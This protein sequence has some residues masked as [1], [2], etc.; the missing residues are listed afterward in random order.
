[1]SRRADFQALTLALLLAA[2]VGCGGDGPREPL[3]VLLVTFDTTRADHIGAYGHAGARTPVLDDLAAQGVLFESAYAP[4]PITLPSHSSL[5]TGKVPFAH[6]VRDNGLFVLGDEQLTLAEIL[7]DRGYRTAAAIASFPLTA[8]FGINQ[9]FELF[10]DHVTADMEDLYGQRSAPKSGIFFDERSAGRVNDAVLPWLE[11]HADEPFFL[12]AHYFDPHHPHTPPPPYDQLFA[13]ELY[14]GE[15]AYAD[16]SL[17]VVLQKL[18]DLGVLDHTLVVFTSDHGEGR[19]EHGEST[20]SL[21][22]YNST[23]H[24]P[25]IISN[26]RLSSELG[27]RRVQQAVSTVDVLPTILELIGLELPAELDGQLQGQSLGRYFQDQPDDGDGRSRRQLYAETLSPRLS[28]QW[29][30]LRTLYYG[31]YKF[32]HGPRPELYDLAADP[33]ELEDLINDRPEIARDL[34][35]RLEGFIADHAVAEIDASVALDDESLRRLQS[36]GYLQASG[37][38]VGPMEER[39]RRDGEAPQDHAE[40]ISIYSRAKSAISQG[41]FL[42]ARDLLRDLLRRDPGNAHYLELELTV[43]RSLGQPEEALRLLDEM[44]KSSESTGYPPLE[45]IQRWRA[46][47][48]LQRGDVDAAYAEYR[49]SLAV[50]PTAQGFHRLAQ[51]HQSRGE[52]QDA[53]RFFKKAI[54]TDPGFAPAHLDLGIALAVE[55]QDEAAEVAFAEALKLQPYSARAHYNFA[56]FLAQTDQVDRAIQ[57]FERA[58]ALRPA[59]PQALQALV[60]LHFLDGD[61]AAARSHLAQ[62]EELAPGSPSLTAARELMTGYAE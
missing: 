13:H 43:A 35:R 53:Q 3:N 15:I 30:E 38:K 34:E 60:E 40:T 50:A 20:H 11:E 28:R 57:R 2:A 44:R 7:R 24:V 61:I 51:I 4:V 19:G 32:I 49:E 31:D 58:L 27:G 36:L 46:D 47:I 21:L 42:E 39:L 52:T 6:G 12:W 56:A 16:E 1:M 54:E 26:P 22:N 55:G 37:D 41:Q 48:L 23:L 14:D 62:L 29:G 10:D 25:L 5:M 18:R 8:Q 59:Y 45:K 17:G 33:R 9:G